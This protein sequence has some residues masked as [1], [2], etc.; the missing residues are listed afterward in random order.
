MLVV[1]FFDEA[2]DCLARFGATPETNVIVALSSD[3]SFDGAANRKRSDPAPNPRYSTAAR[4][5]Q[6]R[7]FGQVAAAANEFRAVRFK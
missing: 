3:S 5:S 4:I 2:D 7:R 6:R 1:V